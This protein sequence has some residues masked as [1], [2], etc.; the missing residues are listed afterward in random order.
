[1]LLVARPL[2]AAAEPACAPDIAL[3]DAAAELLLAG[4]APDRQHLMAAVRGAG[5]DAV[6]VRAL[7]LPADDPAKLDAWLAELKKKSD[8]PLICGDAHAAR[9]RL[10]IASARGGTFWFERGQLRG[11]LAPGF[12]RPELIVRHA[13]GTSERM[14]L[15]TAELEHGIAMDPPHFVS[16]HCNTIKVTNPGRHFAAQFLRDAGV[17]PVTP[18]DCRRSAVRDDRAGSRGVHLAGHRLPAQQLAL[19]HEQKQRQ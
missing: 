12:D 14:A 1:V 7:Y 13:D 8:A 3:T 6:A 16:A 19:T 2:V 17:E 11:T 10:L 4:K 18:R 9:S 5:S 15:S